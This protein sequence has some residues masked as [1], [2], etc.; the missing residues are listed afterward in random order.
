MDQHINDPQS[1]NLYAYGRN[2]PLVYVDPTGRDI[3]LIG[4]EDE[5]K[6]ALELLKRSIAAEAATH[7]QIEERKQGKDTHYFVGIEGDVAD[8]RKL[9]AT[10]NDLAN[11]VTNKNTV[12]FGLT[13]QDLSS[14]GGAVTYEKGEIGNANV[15]VLVNPDQMYAA[16]RVLD[17]S[18]ILGA[19]RWQGAFDKPAWY[20]Q[21]FT[22]AI[23][24]WHEFGHAWAD[25]NGAESQTNWVALVWE[26][27]MRA[28]LYGPLGPRNAP[29]IRH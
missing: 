15:R 19:S 28:Q 5:R 20:P 2:N 13:S 6:K 29:R 21:P 26:N 3:E 18:T 27:R 9:G 25:I 23:A 14:L 4:D 12:E 8:F 10:A 7:L 11:L 22:P 17:S 1:W 16:N 24:A